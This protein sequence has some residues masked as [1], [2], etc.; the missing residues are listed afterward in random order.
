ML[1][2]L[3][4]A[5]ATGRI[6]AVWAL[7][8][9][10]GVLASAVVGTILAFRRDIRESDA[11]KRVARAEAIAA[12][13]RERVQSR[14]T[15]ERR[16]LAARTALREARAE[17][18]SLAA[19]RYGPRHELELIVPKGWIDRPIPIEDVELVLA[20]PN[21]HRPPP[22]NPGLPS[23]GT[24]AD[25]VV[26][27]ESRR[28]D[29]L[30]CFDLRNV[31]TGE[32]PRLELGLTTYRAWIDTCESIAFEFA[33]AA[34]H[35]PGIRAPQPDALPLRAKIDPIARP[36]D[37]LRANVPG[38]AFLLVVLHRGGHDGEHVFYV[39]DR[40]VTN[41]NFAAA[42]VRNA[43]PA[44]AFQP[45]WMTGPNLD[46]ET[47]RKQCSLPRTLAREFIEEMII[48]PSGSS[49]LDRDTL[50]A[51]A[52]DGQDFTK[53]EPYRWVF[54]HLKDPQS[55]RVFWFRAGIN[56]LNLAPELLACVVLDGR[57]L[58][59]RYNPNGEHAMGRS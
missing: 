13:E 33:S 19:Q 8:T 45:D 26:S 5:A 14:Q 37:S 23:P 55:A 30:V 12:A 29:D 9:A 44:G 39:H 2:L 53:T 11:A 24:Y 4:Y 22:Q 40:S 6:V 47:A 31:K 43:V 35:G 15:A 16:F 36:L 20:D 57:R 56:P 27:L 41:E 28:I 58:D 18:S 46:V 50:R 34:G 3:V 59:L 51:M 52:E 54:E 42:N 32:R 7:V 10:G 38:I 25:N 1:C 17:L 49:P 21:L 48:A